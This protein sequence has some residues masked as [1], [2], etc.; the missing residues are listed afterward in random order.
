MIKAVIFDFDH[1]LYDR[2]ATYD[3]MFPI[4]KE[5][6]APYLNRALSD[7][8]LLA[9][10]KQAD[11]DGAYPRGWPDVYECCVKGGIFDTVPDYQTY[12]KAIRT[13]HPVSITL[14]SDTVSTLNILKDM[15]I[16]LGMLTNGGSQSQRDKLE[17]VPEIL[18]LFDKIMIGG[19]LPKEKPHA[20]AYHA[21]CHEL[22]VAPDEAIYVGDHPTNDVEG[23]KLA[24]LTAIWIP[25]VR[26]FPTGV[27]PP[28]FTIEALREIPDI[29]NK[30]NNG[31]NQ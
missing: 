14:F 21:I 24:G 13:A 15:K 31:A 1:T 2:N 25:Y 18:P 9:R 7:E 26:P 10:F 12:M 17:N 16:R 29:I 3:G 19:D 5:L 30:L 6:L 22:D 28:D 23:S 8:E 4:L 20:E 27:T 11:K